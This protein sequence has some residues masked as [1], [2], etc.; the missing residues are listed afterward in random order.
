MSQMW[1]C[2]HNDGPDRLAL[3]TTQA[4]PPAGGA[5]PPDTPPP[6]T[7]PPPG[8]LDPLVAASGLL[9]G[10]VVTVLKQVEIQRPQSMP[11]ILNFITTM[12][13]IASRFLSVRW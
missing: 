9:V 2:I 10:S 8:P 3:P 6:D 7:P 4:G 13:L 12:A 5:P 11:Q 1:T